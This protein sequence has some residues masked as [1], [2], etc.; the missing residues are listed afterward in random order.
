MKQRSAIRRSVYSALFLA[1]LV[2]LI[3]GY[4][5]IFPDGVATAPRASYEGIISVPTEGW[6][7]ALFNSEELL[8]ANERRRGSGQQKGRTVCLV[9][10]SVS[11]PLTDALSSAARDPD[12]SRALWVSFEAVPRIATGPCME[13]FSRGN[14][15]NRTPYGTYLEIKSVTTARPLGCAYHQFVANR[16]RCPAA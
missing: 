4:P 16:L 10:S 7:L 1:G 13:R 5:I 6:G 14:R 12:G 2:A 3:K 9:A 15:A 11:R 8:L